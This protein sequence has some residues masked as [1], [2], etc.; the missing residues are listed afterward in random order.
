MS[1]DNFLQ[2][3]DGLTEADNQFFLG[4]Y[5]C[6]VSLYQPKIEQRTGIGLGKIRVCDYRLHDED[7][8][9]QLKHTWFVRLFRHSLLK[10]RNRRLRDYLESTYEKRA[11]ACMASYYRNTIYVSFSPNIQCHEEG[12][13]YAVVHELSHALWEKVAGQPLDKMR[14]EAGPKGDKFHLLTEGYATYAEVVW[15]LDAYPQCVQ[16][17]VRY[18]E[19][20][21][22]T[23]HDRGMRRISELVKQHGEEILLEIPKRWRSF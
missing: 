15:F 9:K 6:A 4:L 10:S 22:G 8:L 19:P 11:N 1:S 13:A 3:N 12:I 14:Q 5:R 7:V 21:P 20:E 16:K 23:V 18:A 2:I 17:N